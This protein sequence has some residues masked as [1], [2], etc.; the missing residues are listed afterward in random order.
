MPEHTIDSV[1]KLLTEYHRGDGDDVAATDEL[2]DALADLAGLAYEVDVDGN[3]NLTLKHGWPQ[4]DQE[5]GAFTDWQSEVVNGDTTLGFWG[6]VAN[7][8]ARRHD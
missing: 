2:F 3:A 7:R 1:E 4:T 6:W 5:R 8:P